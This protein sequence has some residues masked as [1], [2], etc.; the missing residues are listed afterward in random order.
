M[1]LIKYSKGIIMNHRE[2]SVAA[3]QSNIEYYKDLYTKHTD[4]AKEYNQKLWYWINVMQNKHT[5]PDIDI[6]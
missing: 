2:L 1:H 4:M 5:L 6:T 3:I